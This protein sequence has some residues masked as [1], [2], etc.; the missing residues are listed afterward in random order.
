MTDA[1][2]EQ[3]AL[4]PVQ[5]GEDLV[6]V[7]HH[8]EDVV[9][10]HS[11][12]VALRVDLHG[13][14]RDRHA[15]A[16]PVVHLLAH[17]QQVLVE[18]HAQ[19]ATSRFVH[20][21]QVG[22]ELAL[23]ALLIGEREPLGVRVVHELLDGRLRQLVGREYLICLWHLGQHVPHLCC[24][25]IRCA[26]PVQE[27]HSMPCCPCI[28]WQNGALGGNS[29]Y[30]VKQL[31]HHIDLGVEGCIKL[32]RLFLHK[33]LD[34]VTLG[35]ELEGLKQLHVRWQTGLR[36]HS[37]LDDIG[38]H[39]LQVFDACLEGIEIIMPLCGLDVQDIVIEDPQ[40]ADQ[41]LES[42]VDVQ[43]G[44]AYLRPLGTTKRRQGGARGKL[45]L[46]LTD[47]QQVI[48]ALQEGINVRKDGGHAE[49]PGPWGPRADGLLGDFVQLLPRL[50]GLDTLPQRLHNIIHLPTENILQ[51]DDGCTAHN[52]C[53]AEL[54]QQHRD[55]LRR[56]IE[57]ADVPHHADAVEDGGQ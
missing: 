9:T 10:Q 46:G 19:Q 38:H 57:A 28:F 13:D 26:Q 40:R 51:R 31:L 50:Y 25:V 11:V 22:I 6:I 17:G 39:H 7:A 5:R 29:A 56:V 43:D 24:F 47:L 3:H 8:H 16:L 34:E 33:P 42:R 48:A 44:L 36:L 4:L 15:E 49:V 18:V 45:E 1:V 37:N 21:Q 52:D 32:A 54:A 23:E 35:N 41:L 14:V 55:A 2:V 12:L 30:R 20:G 27:V 53:I